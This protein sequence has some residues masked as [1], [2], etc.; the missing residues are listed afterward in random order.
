MRIIKAQ[1]RQEYAN[2]SLLFA[3][4][5]SG[6]AMFLFAFYFPIHFN[7]HDPLNFAFHHHQTGWYSEVCFV[8]APDRLA[9]RPM[10]SPP[11]ILPPLVAILCALLAASLYG[12]LAKFWVS[13]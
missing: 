1:S 13:Y 12:A 4:Q 8:T 7:E 5:C 11:T 10:Q 9:V 2:L 6:L 3:S